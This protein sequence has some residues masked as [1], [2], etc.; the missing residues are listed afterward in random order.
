MSVLVKPNRTIK[1]VLPWPFISVFTALPNG[2][3]FIQYWLSTLLH[4]SDCYLS[5]H[6]LITSHWV[7]VSMTANGGWVHAV[8]SAD[9]RSI[10]VSIYWPLF[11][12]SWSLPCGPVW[13]Y[14][15]SCMSRS[16]FT[17]WIKGCEIVLWP[18]LSITHCTHRNNGSGFQVCNGRL[19]WSLAMVSRA[20]T[21][22]H[23]HTHTF[24]S[25]FWHKESELCF[26]P[27]HVY[28]SIKAAVGHSA[29][30][31]LKCSVDSV[32]YPCPFPPRYCA[33]K[34][35]TRCGLSFPV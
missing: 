31:L 3:W 23:T 21:H 1:S 28:L 7:N 13:L 34:P 12:T 33:A 8:S 5:Q 35:Q 22:V 30:E 2:Q 19:L 16:S 9:V 18:W 14:T 17:D 27:L 32:L 4:H 24:Q 20:Q 26:I 10:T 25:P 6:W 15:L 11:M 29:S